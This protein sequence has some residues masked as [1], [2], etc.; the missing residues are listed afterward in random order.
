MRTVVIEAEA[1]E[2]L[3]G[4]KNEQPEKAQKKGSSSPPVNIL[5]G[6]PSEVDSRP[7]DIK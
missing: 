7:A 3:F 2:S 5:C 4:E 1:E 6:N